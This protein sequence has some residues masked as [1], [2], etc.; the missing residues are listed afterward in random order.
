MPRTILIMAGG[1]GGHIYPG[2]AVAEALAARGW[3][4][5]WMGARG[6]MEAQVVPKHGIPIEWIRFSGVRG[7]ALARFL[8]L[9]GELLVAFW[10]AAAVLRRVRPDV[11][12]GMGGYISFPGGMMAAFLG[13][14]LAVHEQ[15]AVA[16][17]ATRVLAKLAD[18][19][20]ETF[21][22]TLAGARITG[23]P[24][25]RELAAVPA[26]GMRF[27][28][29]SGRLRLTVIGGSLGATALN[30]TVPAAL[31]LLAPG[32]RPQVLHQ[33]GARHLERLEAN[34][35]SAGVEATTVA[36]VED[37]AGCLAETDLVIGRAGATSLAEL[38]CVGVGAVLVPFPH[39][40]DDHQT[41]NARHYAERGAAVL[42]PQPELTP[43]RLAGI[44][45]AFDRPRL[46][47]MAARARSLARPDAAERVA[48][49]CEEL[50][51]AA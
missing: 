12:L 22:D 7:K 39:A 45:R 38:A 28:N 27:E 41:M 48:D 20:L 24:V 29:R 36:F 46:A 23:N 21:P 31:A 47:E 33:S 10:Q 14:P 16:G 9:P 3:R 50:A 25:R 18:R 8:F 35:R 2:L 11:V 44:V 26:P 1:T 37:M 5:V 34:Y 49:A 17:T 19:V 13:R 32:E 51:R 6:G 15:N 4:V 40:I 30:E 42:L 43:E